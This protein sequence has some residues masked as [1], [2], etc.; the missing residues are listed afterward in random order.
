[1]CFRL[2]KAGEISQIDYSNHIRDTALNVPLEQVIP[3]FAA[4]KSWDERLYHED[5]CI[6]Y[7]L[8]PGECHTNFNKNAYI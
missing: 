5:N 3:L 7:K 2:N 1:M 8:K 4:M 6:T